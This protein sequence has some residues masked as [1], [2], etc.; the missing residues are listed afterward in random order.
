MLASKWMAPS[1]LGSDSI[2]ELHSVAA[3][4]ATV[5]STENHIRSINRRRMVR[6]RRSTG[7]IALCAMMSAPGQTLRD[8]LPAKGAEMP[9]VLPVVHDGMSA[10]LA[11]K[12]GFEAITVGGFPLAGARLG[13]PDL[14]LIGFGGAGQRPSGLL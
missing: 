8:L 12:A 2:L 1:S 9:L 13:L 11:E 3:A 6:S 5:A 14:A 10:R 7:V 4:G